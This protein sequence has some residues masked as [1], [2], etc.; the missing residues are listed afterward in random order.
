MWRREN[1]VN[2]DVTLWGEYLILFLEI[3]LQKF[4][5]LIIEFDL[6]VLIYF[7]VFYLVF[8]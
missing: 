5:L 6:F 2:D 3:Y 8:I 1:T 7:Q 4:N